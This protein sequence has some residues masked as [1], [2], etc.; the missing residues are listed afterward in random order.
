MEKIK[1][2]AKAIVAIVG[3][4]LTTV[5][6]QFPDSELLQEWGPIVASLLT[7]ISV[8]MIPNK[9][10]LALHQDESVMPPGA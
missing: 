4:V 5:L 6:V 7:A 2:Y 9:D 8:Y 3:A 1:P 10:P